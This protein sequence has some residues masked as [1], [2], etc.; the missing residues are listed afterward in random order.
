MRSISRMKKWL[1]PLFVLVAL[2]IAGCQNT[3]DIMSVGLSVDATKIE[4]TADGTFEVTW[5]LKNPNVATY[6]MD[7][8]THKLFIDGTL[9]GTINQEG[10]IAIPRDSFAEHTD[11]LIL[12]PSPAAAKL[13]QVLA[14]GS[15]NY[16]LET[17]AW[18][19]VVDEQIEKSILTGAGTV[20]VTAK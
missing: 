12:G 10:R 5:R 8:S 14:Q 3:G 16:R 15:A 1:T 20:P 2:F 9:V 7:H 13:A 11:K 4:R 19:L 18:M 6:L 17:L